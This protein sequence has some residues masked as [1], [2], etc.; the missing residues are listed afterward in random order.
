MNKDYIASE[1]RRMHEA[2]A[3]QG[4]S[5][6]KHLAEIK[7][8]IKLHDIKTILDYGSGKGKLSLTLPAEVTLYDPYHEPISKKPEGTFDMVICNDVLEHIPEDEAGQVIHELIN[9]T[10]KVLFLS[11]C[12]KPASK[13][14]SDGTNVH[15]TV[16]P[17]AWW[18]GMFNTHRNV[19][20]VRHYT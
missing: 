18:E 5:L 12:T 4:N 3:F 20:I 11:I 1:Y 19:I 16:K 7:A 10:D 14:F 6:R 8:L 9:M 13:K 17:E 2:G 15:I